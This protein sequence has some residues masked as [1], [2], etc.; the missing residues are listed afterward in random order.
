M[1][2]LPLILPQFGDQAGRFQPTAWLGHTPY[3]HHRVVH[4]YRSRA[5]LLSST[6]RV[7]SRA[8]G[9]LES[10]GAGAG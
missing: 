8:G 3:I 2:D 1:V 5:H 6:R 4:D 9:C 10:E 7:W